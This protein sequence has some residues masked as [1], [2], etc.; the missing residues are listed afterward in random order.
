MISNTMTVTTTPR[1]ILTRLDRVRDGSGGRMATGKLLDLGPLAAA[2][3][4]GLCRI[5]AAVARR[6]PRHN[7]PRRIPVPA[8]ASRNGANLRINVE[9]SHANGGASGRPPPKRSEWGEHGSDS[10]G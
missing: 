2:L 10:G 3:P 1:L 5:G 9:R 7:V 8:G 4:G 6:T